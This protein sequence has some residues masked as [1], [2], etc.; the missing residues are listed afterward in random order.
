MQRAERIYTADFL[1]EL[2]S[3]EVAYKNRVYL[4]GSI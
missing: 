4:R 3:V 2:V 1:I